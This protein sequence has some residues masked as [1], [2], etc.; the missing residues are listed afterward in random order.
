MLHVQ[1]QF[2]KH[3]VSRRPASIK[4]SLQSV[5][6]VKYIVQLSLF[7]KNRIPTKLFNQFYL[8]RQMMN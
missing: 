5:N 4:A 1:P 2:Y 3:T 7:A 8:L 6:T